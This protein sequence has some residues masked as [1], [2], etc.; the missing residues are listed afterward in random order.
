MGVRTRIPV[1]GKTLARMDRTDIWVGGYHVPM[2]SAF[3]ADVDVSEESTPVFGYDGTIDSRVINAGTLSLT[4]YEH[5]DA[6]QTFLDVLQN[7]NPASAGLRAY[8]PEGSYTT[9]VV[10]NTKHPTKNYYIMGE[11]FGAWNTLL[12][13]KQG[14]VK[15]A[16][17]RQLDGR[18]AVPIEFRVRDKDDQ[19]VCVAMDIAAMATGSTGATGNLASHNGVGSLTAIPATVPDYGGKYALS[20]EIQQRSSGDILKAARLAVTT[21]MVSSAGLVTV[22]LNDLNGTPF[23]A[24]SEITHAH[25]YFIIYQTTPTGTLLLGDGIAVR[26]RWDTET[27]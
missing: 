25:V 7:I 15:A 12:R 18:C 14:D 3:V 13:P 6:M 17:V 26:G 4:A 8:K 16:G 1:A 24:L 9:D 2:A 23:E 19:A 20:V 5:A 27:A 11:F 21:G 22:T 10:R